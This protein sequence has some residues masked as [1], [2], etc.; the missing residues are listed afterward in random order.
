[1]ADV[2]ERLM[3]AARA[4]SEVD[5]IAL[6]ND[7]E[8]DVLAKS[9]DGTTALMRAAEHGNEGCIRLL[10]PASDA[11]AQDNEGWTALMHAAYKGYKACVHHLLPVSDALAKA[12]D[13]LTANGGLTA[14]MWAAWSGHEAC[15]SLLLPA[16][17]A[18]AKAADGRTASAWAHHHGHESAARFIDAYALAQSEQV[19]IGVAVSNEAVR[20][21]PARRV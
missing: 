19:A 16:S 1:M 8:C 4:G 15:I 2:N 18:S 5:L 20:G 13:G 10:L 14:L 6:L 7:P 3:N 12:N 21:R 17:D 11:L 9:K